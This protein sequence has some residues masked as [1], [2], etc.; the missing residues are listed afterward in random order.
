MNKVELNIIALANAE[1]SKG[2]FVLVLEE[3]N[4]F[5]RLPII[6]GAF[7]AQAIAVQLEKIHSDRPS[8]H[9]L[10][11]N[12]VEALAASITEVIIHN[13]IEGT[14]Y[15]MLNGEKADGAA[16]EIHARPSDAVALA[17]RFGCPIFTTEQIMQQ[18]SIAA[19]NPSKTF[20]NKGDDFSVYSLVELRKLLEQVLAKEDYESASRIRD[21]IKDKTVS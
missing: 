7:E 4:G 1:S 12:T 13:L 14:F 11:K 21:A 20:M 18:A 2:D 19:E 6:I 5:R 15:A 8:T 17:I 10:Y 16:L 3:E 9:D